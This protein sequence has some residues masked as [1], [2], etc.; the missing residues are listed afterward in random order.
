MGLIRPPPEWGIEPVPENLRQLR[1]IDIFVFWTSLSI[2]LLVLQAGALLTQGLS[3]PFTYS[4]IIIVFGSIVGSLILALVGVIGSSY[5]V[6]TMV[7]LRPVFGMKGSYVP[8]ILNV[9][10]LIGWTSFELIIMGEAAATISGPIFGDYTKFLW[11]IFFAIICYFM[12]VSGPLIV[13]RQWL[14]KFALWICLAT[15]CWISFQIMQHPIDLKWGN[16]GL[17][18]LL[19]AF[20]IVV[21]MPISWMPLV[22][23]YNR[24][25][26]TKKG[27]FIGT[28]LG[29]TFANVWFYTLGAA[30]ALIGGSESVVYSIAL[31]L[32]GNIALFALLVDETDNAFADIYSAAVSL[33]NIFSK[34]RQW[35]IGLIITVVATAIAVSTPIMAYEWFLLLIGAAFIPVFGIAF[36][37]YYIINRGKYDSSTFLS[38]ANKVNLVAIFSWILGFLSYWYFSYIIGLGGTVPS[39]IIAFTV[40]TAA[41]KVMTR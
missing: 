14:E 4:S 29:Y 3:L 6:P 12:M 16:V 35:F 21:A 17:D 18:S 31:M 20:D 28:F 22:S 41:K 26:S 8:T 30:L 15:T 40:Y 36:S 39:F 5:G 10:Q 25:A 19:L 38:P 9:V 7:S 2:G 33:Q 27:G 37:D 34:Q 32:L 23:D 13:I 1:A 24:F 11:I